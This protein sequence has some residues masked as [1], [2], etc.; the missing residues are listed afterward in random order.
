M[1]KES[2]VQAKQATVVM[3][4]EDGGFLREQLIWMKKE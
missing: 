3:V 1:S 4:H 2:E